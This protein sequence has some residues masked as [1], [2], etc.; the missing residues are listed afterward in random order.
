MIDSYGAARYQSAA[1]GLETAV[2]NEEM[3]FSSMCST[4]IC[5]DVCRKDSFSKES[6]TQ[7]DDRVADRLACYTVCQRYV[8]LPLL[9]SSWHLLKLL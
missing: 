2:L 7:W 6:N 1:Q 5:P 4:D 3:K 8:E 9:S